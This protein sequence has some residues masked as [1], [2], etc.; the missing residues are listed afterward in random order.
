MNPTTFRRP[1]LEMCRAEFES[2]VQSKNMKK[3][4][5][6]VLFSSRETT[7]INVSRFLW[8]EKITILVTRYCSLLIILVW[9]LAQRWV[10]LKKIHFCIVIVHKSIKPLSVHNDLLVSY[11]QNCETDYSKELDGLAVTDFFMERR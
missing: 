7:G 1:N 4:K 6:F 2:T 3:A 11:N 10:V 5:D 8:I 9:I